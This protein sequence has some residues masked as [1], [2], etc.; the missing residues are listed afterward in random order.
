MQQD[1]A[2]LTEIY[3]NGRSAGRLR[4]D[5]RLVPAPGQ[6]LLAHAHPA[7]P[8]AIPVFSAGACPGGFYAAP[9]LPTDWQPGTYLHIRGPLGKGFQLAQTARFVALA[10]FGQS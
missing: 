8:L 1:S 6:Y 10:A 9:P 5:P 2:E 7:D 3:L 4:C